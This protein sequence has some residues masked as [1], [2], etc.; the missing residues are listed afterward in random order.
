M[1]MN[2]LKYIFL[3]QMAMQSPQILTHYPLGNLKEIL[4]M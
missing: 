1:P 4:D 3:D 2:Y